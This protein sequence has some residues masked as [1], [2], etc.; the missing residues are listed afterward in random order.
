M[1]RF[2]IDRPIFA[3]VM[4]ILVMLIGVIS[5]I[6]L[7]IEQY[8]RIA[9]PTISV[10]A[11][12]PG[13]NAQT[14]EDSVVQIIEQR[15]KGLDGLMYM[16]SSSS[17]N[18]GAS[19]TLTFEN[20]TDPDT[21]QVQ[22]QNKLQAAMS[23]L[24]ESVQRQG[25]NVNK[26]SSSFLMVQGFISEDGSMDNSDIA[27]YI[28]SNVVDQLS[29]VEGVGEVQVFGSAY[30]MRI[31]LD[32]SLLRS[33]NLVP[34]D[35][36][37]AVRAQN[38]QV[39]AG[40]L[41][42]A[43]ADTDRQV[44]N[45]TVTVQSYL[46]TPE[47]FKNILLKTDTSG[48]KVRLGDVAKVEIGSENYSVTALYNGQSSAG[49]G[50]SLAGGAN[51]LETREAV[52]ARM[53]ELEQN[54]PKNLTTVVPYDTTP[55]VRL[56]IE[57]VV[58]T[59]IEAIVLVFIVMFIFL[60]N[61]R[62]TIIPTLAVPVVLLGTFAVLYIAGFSINVLT[63][64]AL[65]LS[66]G[67]LVDDAI[68]VVENV[69]RI[70]EEDPHISIK[71]ATIQ[72]MGE[73]SKIVVGIALILSA[74]FVPMAF[75][76]GS[77]GVIYRQF[78]ITLITAMVLS[79]L[80]ALIFTPALCVTLLK[81]SK[82]H[83]KGSTE[84]QKGF[85]GWFNRSFYKVS[86]KYENSVGK[87]FKFK[88]LYLIG[89]AAI[90]G[91]MAV[92]FLRIPGSFLPEED[93][94]IMFT[95]VQLPAGATLDETEAV[96][97][98]V[99]NYY[100][101][102]EKDNVASVFSVAGF[103]FA[104]Q[105]QNM[106]LAFVRLTDWAERSGDENTAQAVAGRAMG[107]FFTQLNEAQ[108]FAIVPPAI[109][110]LGNASGFDLMIQDTGNV[111]HEGLLEA[112]NMLLG[113]AAQNDQVT[114]VRPNGQEDAPQLKININQ[115]QAAAYGLSLANINSVISTAWG[116]SY[117]NDFVDRG[118]IKRVFVQGEPSSRTNPDD[119]GKWYV[120]NDAGEMIPFDAFSSSEWQ[121]GSPRLTRYNSLP[122]MNIQGSAAPGLSTGE[123]MSS[124]EAMMQ[125]LPEG[126]GYEWTGMS[127][128]EQKSGAQ[129]PML[130][131]LSI[132]VVF[133][134][135]AALYESWSI[136]FSV[137]LVIPLGVLG[138]VIFT[139]LRG[140]NNDIYLQVGLLT[141]VGLSAKNAILIIEFAKEHQEEGNTL[142]EAVMIAARQRLR[143]II[144]TSLAFG[145]GVVPL[146]IATGPG[147]GSQNAI[148]TSVVGGVVTATLLGIFFIPMFF[149]WVRS[150]FP[151]KYEN[152]KPN[153]K[154]DGDDGTPGPQ[155]P[156]PSDP[157]PSDSYQPAS[158]GDN[159]Q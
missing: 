105:G 55:F 108:V 5:V 13:A 85:F 109:T 25:V 130:Y 133:L 76:G 151:Y 150:L 145:L 19:V 6:N 128:E 22:V 62:A 52:G 114:G 42:Q 32:P 159:I 63:M 82:S 11:S 142:K 81:R 48:A 78:S 10:S 147:S 59:L 115:E 74:V 9:P 75:F 120:R 67:L 56:S 68:V 95:L 119:I 30:A 111:G 92:V 96:L 87:S 20:G 2:F 90:I 94:G 7:P 112:R 27:D 8:P 83:E 38:A 34:A 107:Y 44:I 117:I 113:M 126:I 31:W 79:A 1:S 154:D 125:K 26:S 45:A 54:F 146:F 136:P 132:L 88:W 104:G 37:N 39:S 134:C 57:Q 110:E 29:R 84:E 70:L 121:S 51:A 152:N 12:Y 58:K 15:M 64:F 17:S 158:F 60:Q 93:Q 156:T 86:R 89:Y 103:S 141:V 98:K 106:G 43:P 100:E 72:S 127:L 97:E 137:L 135:L 47:E 3:W 66:I 21:A 101:T 61:W 33:Y 24:P 77:T 124:M 35:V 4:A 14:V 157:M 153:N 140:F 28:N 143:P 131:A 138:A 16:S 41:G 71:D 149:I 123:A 36:V 148:G 53:A 49:L 99:T 80:V 139:W 46:Q 91:V 122:S 40:Q 102:Q 129:A 73:I 116:S 23:S 65:V 118:R 18:G 50:I 155:N 144:M 69:E